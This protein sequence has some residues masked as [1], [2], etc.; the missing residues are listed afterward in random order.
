MLAD[1]SWTDLWGGLLNSDFNYDDHYPPPSE[2]E[3]DGTSFCYA[4]EG[5]ELWAEQ[6]LP[7][8]SALSSQPEQTAVST[9]REGS[10]NGPAE[11]LCYGMVCRPHAC[12]LPHEIISLLLV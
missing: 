3:T 11:Q 10:M 6:D 4:Q 2:A 9:T 12:A 5:I 8:S 7:S 1:Q